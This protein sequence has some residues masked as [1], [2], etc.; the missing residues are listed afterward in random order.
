MAMIFCRECKTEISSK[1][2]TCPKCG[3][4]PAKKTSLITWIIG[5]IVLVVVF[6]SCSSINEIEATTTG[7]RTLAAST[8]PAV[9]TAARA[10]PIWEYSTEND[11]MTSKPIKYAELKSINSL[12]L[13]RPYSGEN[14]GKLL[15]RKRAGRSDEVMLTFEQGQ[16]M[17]RSYS[18]DCAIMVRFDDAQ[19]IKFAGQTPSDGSSTTIFLTP[20]AK[21]LTAG[22]KAKTMKVS[23]EIYKAGIQV[24]EFAP[25]K[26]LVWP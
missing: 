1:A 11:Q 12:S 3:A 7:A 19:P 25:E 16:S 9:P 10:V 20:A 21:F 4:K 5:A 15:V 24:F 6:R 2:V 26:P 22:Q 23:L 13:E 17:C 8:T 18:A 14:Y